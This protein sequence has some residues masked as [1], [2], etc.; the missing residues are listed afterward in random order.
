MSYFP[1]SHGIFIKQNHIATM[2]T[3]AK[4]H[5]Y[6]HNIRANKVEHKGGSYRLKTWIKVVVVTFFVVVGV[7]L[8][9]C[10]AGRCG[11][12][13][14]AD[15]HPSPAATTADSTQWKTLCHGP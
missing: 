6:N 11:S 9:L 14:N 2:T 5:G 3:Y 12:M 15:G 7:V 13:V 8:I 4:S 1:G 10:S